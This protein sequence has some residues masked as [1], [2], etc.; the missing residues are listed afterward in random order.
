MSCHGGVAYTCS[1]IVS[2]CRAVGRVIES[3]QGIGWQLLKSVNAMEHS[4]HE[5]F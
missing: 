5:L 2:A 3:R 1:G 4:V